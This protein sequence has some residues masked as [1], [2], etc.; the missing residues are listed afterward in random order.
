LSPRFT[1]LVSDSHRA[2]IDIDSFS[3]STANE[4]VAQAAASINA[5]FLSPVAT[6]YASNVTDIGMVRVAFCPLAAIYHFDLKTSPF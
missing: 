2:R 1:A 4:R 5:D 3:K 6:S